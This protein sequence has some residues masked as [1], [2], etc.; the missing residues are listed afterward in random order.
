M[1]LAANTRRQDLAK[2][3][4]FWQRFEAGIMGAKIAQHETAPE[5]SDA[6]Q[7]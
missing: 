2:S 6:G 3:S 7:R 5:L 4:A 1:A